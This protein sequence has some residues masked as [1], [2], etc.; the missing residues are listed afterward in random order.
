MKRSS[1]LTSLFLALTLS[2]TAGNNRAGAGMPEVRIAVVSDIHV[3]A[4]ELLE[5]EGK[6]FDS[7]VSRDRKML[8]ESSSILKELTRQLLEAKPQLV[9]ISGD[10]TKDGEYS[11]HHYLV[12]NCLNTLNTAGIRTLVVPGNHDV[13]NPNAFSF[14]G[15]TQ[16]QVKTITPKEFAECYADYGYGKSIARDKYSLSYVSEPF[17]NLRILAIDA[18]EYEDNDFKNNKCITGGRIKPETM[19]FIRKQ[20]ADAKIKGIQ[21]F[22]MMHHGLV[23]HWKGQEDMM[24]DYLIDDWSSHADAFAEM[25]LNVVF[26]GHFHA[27]DIVKHE[28]GNAFVYDIETGSTLTYPCPY[29]LIS[30]KNENISIETRNISAIDYDLKGATF[31]DYAKKYL[32]DGLTNVATQMLP[33]EIPDTIK[34][35]ISGIL[36]T[37]MIAHSSGDE[38]LCLEEKNKAENLFNALDKIE[39]LYAELLK[40]G[41][42]GIWQDYLPADNHLNINLNNLMTEENRGS[43]IQKNSR[44]DQ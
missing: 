27:Q 14:N 25:G 34:S 8:K 6:A 35:A 29:R 32:V 2:L 18:C 16:Q 4:P 40:Q 42:Y 28:F 39:P 15:D 13:N 10:L 30:M 22:A 31:Q 38:F 12:E 5:K 23:Q 41:F 19:D 21:I 3:M 9:L 26:T 43:Q 7:Y 24:K 11:S 33:G 44:L 1:K 36:A 17:E 37:T 20:V